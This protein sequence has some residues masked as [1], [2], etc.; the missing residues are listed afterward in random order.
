M[1]MSGKALS[2]SQ[3]DLICNL[4]SV[5]IV[6][7]SPQGVAKAQDPSSSPFPICEFPLAVM[8]WMCTVRA[9]WQMST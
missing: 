8:G 4:H 2:L 6:M 7:E 9:A 5:A 1:E 3:P